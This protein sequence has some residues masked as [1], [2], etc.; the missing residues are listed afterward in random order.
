[1]IAP[2]P[3]L[4]IVGWSLCAVG[5][6]AVVVGGLMAWQARLHNAIV[7]DAVDD[8]WP[9]YVVGG[10]GI[11]AVLIGLRIVQLGRRRSAD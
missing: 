8:L 5:T 9:A 1:M 10:L 4:R 7:A 11:L 6:V 2:E 3:R